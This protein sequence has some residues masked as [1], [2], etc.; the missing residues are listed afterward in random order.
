M[1]GDKGECVN[2]SQSSFGDQ[3]AL[4]HPLEGGGEGERGGGGCLLYSNQ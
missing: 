1:Q 2:P 3:I 4:P